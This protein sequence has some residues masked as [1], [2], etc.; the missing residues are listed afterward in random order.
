VTPRDATT[1]P[2]YAGTPAALLDLR[3]MRK[4]YNTVLIDCG[5]P[6]R[7]LPQALALLTFSRRF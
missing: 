2:Q 5:T 3:E 1:A 7:W 6:R 4:K